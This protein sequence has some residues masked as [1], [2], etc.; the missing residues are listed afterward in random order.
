MSGFTA[1]L[2]V[3]YCD[4]VRTENTGKKIHV[5]VYSSALLLSEIPAKLP[6]FMVLIKLA[7][8]AA[9]V[10]KESIRFVLLLD[11]KVLFEQELAPEMVQE[12]PS[13]IKGEGG[14]AC[15]NVEL[16]FQG[17]DIENAGTLRVRAYVDGTEYRGLALDIRQSGNL[18]EAIA[19]VA[20]IRG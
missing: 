8:A 3:I 18:R 19:A 14:I 6:T 2:E 12:I 4:D 20:E 11:D 9:Y 16:R 1:Q 7:M 17:F 5:G 15:A 13:Q 10:P